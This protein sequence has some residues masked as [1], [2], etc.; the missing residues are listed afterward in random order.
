MTAYRIDVA[1]AHAH[2]F[3]VTVSVAQP[4]AEQV[5]SLPVWVPGSYLV[6]E[7]ARHLSQLE[8]R[9]GQ[10]ARSVEQLDKASWRVRCRG[11]ATLTLSYLVYAFDTSVRTAFLDATRGF[12]NGTSVFV[13]VHG[14][15]RAPQQVAI[16]TLP[17]IGR[18]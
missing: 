13:R 15:E 1:D 17:Q 7:F 11:R 12:F 9:Q 10:Q 14:A 18:A 16:G 6:R 4:A 5:V 2:L 3:R 8:A